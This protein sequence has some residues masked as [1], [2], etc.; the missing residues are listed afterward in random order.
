[1][2]KTLIVLLVLVF[3]VS[4]WAMDI[5]QG[6]YELTG[7][8][9]FDFATSSLD[10]GNGDVDTDTISLELD[11]QYYFQKNI[12]LGVSFTYNDTDVDG[13]ALDSTFW[14]I[15]PQATYNISID[16]K[17]SF[18][19]N[20]MIGYANYDIGNN[21][22]DGFGFKV[23]GG[24]KYFFVNNV[25]L[26]GQLKYTWMNLDPDF[27]PDWDYSELSLGAGLAVVF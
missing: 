17:L 24:V 3:P 2:K 23:G 15:G 25:A 27:G 13:S 8:T 6:K 4:L 7:T 19:V 18:F 14:M 12:A 22:S 11:G 10:T 26:V 5:P 20:G 21:D 9:S 1:M 16:P